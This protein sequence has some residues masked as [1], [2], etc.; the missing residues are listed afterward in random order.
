MQQY[1]PESIL[2]RARSRKSQFRLLAQKIKKLKAA[3]SDEV[4]YR[5]HHKV[6]VH[7]NC[8]DCGNCCLNLGPRLLKSD[9]E[10][11]ARSLDVQPDAFHDLY[12]KRDEDGDLVFKS[13]PCPFLGCN[14]L[15][16]VYESRPRAC[17]EYPHT[18][19]RNI[20]SILHLCIK[21]TETCPAVLEIFE[22]LAVEL[23]ND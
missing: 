19:Q 5:L 23:K 11:M 21:N 17:R 16:S 8:L 10:R 22:K 13:M 18:D 6:F 7:I 14:N 2:L 9:V 20:K 4:F 1:N 12:L 3:Q 15:C